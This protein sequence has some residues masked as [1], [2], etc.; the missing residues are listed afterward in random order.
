MGIDTPASVILAAR[1][2][3]GLDR[4]LWLQYLHYLHDLFTGNLGNSLVSGT[5]VRDIM[6]QLTPATLE[7]GLSAFV[8]VIVV[9]LPLGMAIGIA[10]RDGRRRWLHL[11]FASATGVLVSVPDYL[12]SVGLVFVFAVTFRL[13]PVAGQ[14]GPASYVLPVIALASGPV[15]Y[16]ARIVRAE[17]QRVLAEEYIQTARVEAA[18][19]AAAV[20][21]S[22]PSEHPHRDTDCQRARTDLAAGR[23]CPGR[24]RVRLAR[25]RSRAGAIGAGDRFP[26]RPGCRAVLRVS[27]PVDQ[28]GCRHSDRECRSAF[29]HQGELMFH[30]RWPRVLRS[31][32]AVI[33]VVLL[34]LLLCVALIGPLLLSNRANAID[35]NAI[36]QGMSARHPF[37]TDAL[38]RDILARTVVAGRLSVCLALLAT[39]LGT[40]FGVVVGSLPV[41]VGR[42]RG[43]LIVAAFNLLVAF[44]GLLLALFLAL[45][46]GVGARG[47]VLAVAV[48]MAPSFARLT[49]TTASG[50]AG[51]DYVAAAKLLGVPRRKML[52]RHVLPNIAEPLLV[53]ATGQVGSALLSLSALS[54]LG[55]GVQPPGYDWGRMLSDGLS[56][57]YT[58]PA[59]ALA[60]CVAIIVAG[61]TFV[62]VGEVLTQLVAGQATVLGR[63]ARAAR[64]IE[65]DG[66]PADEDWP[67]AP[68]EALRVSNLTVSFPS[69][70]LPLTPVAGVSFTVRG[71][72]IVGIVGESGSGKSLTALAISSLVSYPGVTSATAHELGS[73]SLPAMAPAWRGNG[74]SAPRCRWSFKIR[75]QP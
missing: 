2:R 40:L 65:A 41:I 66:T 13:L 30:P 74:S 43:R 16:L 25:H 5:P 33:T 14:N 58:N 71:G 54:Y 62:L 55:F 50:I 19:G 64:Q 72:E 75:C 60:P 37:G 11:S 63:S 21:T 28:P 48:G 4:P 8:V 23:D 47:A 57:I 34:A 6:T 10:A 26:G 61:V 68:G 9:A 24:E 29:H 31:P 3:L 39:G 17:T 73:N 56:S 35:V 70:G 22:C 38:G 69:A 59:A 67:V 51:S 42:R 15:C 32:L 1:R 27:C 49:H 7:L 53:N 20:R 46:F 12:L 45:V 52:L 18:P 44:P 36:Q